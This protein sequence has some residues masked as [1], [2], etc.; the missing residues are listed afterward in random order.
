MADVEVKCINKLPRNNTHEV[1]TH[2]G[3]ALEDFQPR[4]FYA[5]VDADNGD[6]CAGLAPVFFFVKW[7]GGDCGTFATHA[8]EP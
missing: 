7:L 4:F 8:N 1:N 3:N 6:G 2:L 5:G